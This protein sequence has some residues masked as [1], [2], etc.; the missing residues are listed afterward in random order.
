MTCPLLALPM[1]VT[2]SV[3][4]GT[5]TVNRCQ[6]VTEPSACWSCAHSVSVPPAVPASKTV[7]ATLAGVTSISWPPV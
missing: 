2:L 1:L 7:F 3:G 6:P 5:V 4:A